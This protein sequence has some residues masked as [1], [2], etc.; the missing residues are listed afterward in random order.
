VDT[1]V[2]SGSMHTNVLKLIAV[3]TK[4]SFRK[5]NKRRKEKQRKNKIK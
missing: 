5:Q 1:T 4:K 3:P 2:K